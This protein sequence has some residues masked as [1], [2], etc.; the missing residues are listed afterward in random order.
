MMII[1]IIKKNT[2]RTCLFILD[3][4][5]LNVASM[6]SAKQYSQFLQCLIGYTCISSRSHKLDSKV[7][8]RKV[9]SRICIL[10]TIM[11]VRYLVN[12]LVLILYFTGVV[13]SIFNIKIYTVT[14]IFYCISISF[15]FNKQT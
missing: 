1:I 4:H 8:Y 3:A 6:S 9:R 14:S 15:S 2:K 12:G 10:A 5:G 11:V 7:Y 13:L